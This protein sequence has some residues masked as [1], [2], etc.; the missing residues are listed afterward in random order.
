MTATVGPDTQ[1]IP[2]P[3]G[4]QGPPGPPGAP[5]DAPQ[6][7]VHNQDTPSSVWW[8]EHDLGYHPNVQSFDSA[9]SE[10]EGEVNHI[11]NNTLTI[12]FTSAFGG[13][14]YLS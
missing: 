13:V 2:G 7:Y 14:A 8:V 6:A 9:G 4:P 1:L 12:T 3:P 10:W 11:D 5:G